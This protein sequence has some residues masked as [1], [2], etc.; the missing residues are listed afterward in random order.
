[1]A[2]LAFS[3]LLVDMDKHDLSL[4]HRI[5]HTYKILFP[6]HLH[7]LSLQDWLELLHALE[8]HFQGY[9]RQ[10]SEQIEAHGTLE[11]SRDKVDGLGAAVHLVWV[12]DCG[13]EIDGVV[14]AW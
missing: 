8:C 9:V 7:T 1:L 11:M 4:A 5:Y 13:D 6:Y 14:V 3:S 12:V 10:W 2:P